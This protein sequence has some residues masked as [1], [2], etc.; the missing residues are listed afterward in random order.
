MSGCAA[1]GDTSATAESIWFLVGQTELT[2]EVRRIP[3]SCFP[4]RI[5]RRSDLSLRLVNQTVSSEHAEIDQRAGGLIVRDLQSTNG[6]YLNGTPVLGEAALC[7]NDLLQF[8]DMAFRL[9]REDAG[10]ANH[11]VTG[12]A[13]DRAVALLQFDKLM[14]GQAAIPHFQPIVE[15][16]N[17][18]VIG[19]EVVGRSRLYGLKNPREMFL[20]AAQ[21]NLQAELSELFRREGIRAGIS[22][23]GSANLFVNTHPIE[24]IQDGLVASLHELREITATHPITLEIHEAA[25][26]DPPMMIELHALLRDLDIQLAYDD[27]GAGQA[28]LIELV[29]VRPDYLKF[30]MQLV[31]GIHAAPAKRQQMLATLVEMVRGLG[32]APLAEGV[33]CEEDSIA[34]QQFGFELGQGFLY[35]RPAAVKHFRR[36]P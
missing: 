29:E 28:R 19:Y 27:F 5:G 32:I 8:S 14:D 22:L 26:T 9:H 23:A 36:N 6:T 21:L 2:A 18:Q 10:V 11:T 30:D 31:Q 1:P 25:V 35:G 15:L 17:L 34:C 13:G 12:D 3:I 7:A 24:L 16:E 20:A 4:F 33:E